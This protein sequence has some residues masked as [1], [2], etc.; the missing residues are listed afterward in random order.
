MYNIE[1]IKDF[2]AH[3]T[4][5]TISRNETIKTEGEVFFS[6]ELLPAS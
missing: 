5:V 6:S 1:N 2:Y 3:L 4:W